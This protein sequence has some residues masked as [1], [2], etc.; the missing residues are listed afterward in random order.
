MFL[1]HDPIIKQ[2]RK[3]KTYRR[4]LRKF[5]VRKERSRAESLKM[6]RPDFNFDHMIKERYPTFVEALR[7]LDDAV[8][9]VFLFATLPQN[10]FLRDHV[11]ERCARL[12]NE[13]TQYIIKSR[14]LRRVFCSIKGIYFQANVMGELVTWLTPYPYTP[15]VPENVDFKVMITFLEFHMKV[16][17][18]QKNQFDVFFFLFF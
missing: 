7:D 13:W 16:R 1:M 4:K 17:K 15:N 6:T 8:S 3:Y 10:R 9:M 11:I 2:I 18:I 5:N 12:S 14:S